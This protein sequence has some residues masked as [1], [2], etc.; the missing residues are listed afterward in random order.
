MSRVL[1]VDDEAP[2][3][4]ALVADLRARGYETGVASTG[5][6]ALRLVA[7]DAPDVV[8]LDLGPPGHGRR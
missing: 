8:I 7:R 2:I 1:V 4:R 3:Q 5:E 6:N